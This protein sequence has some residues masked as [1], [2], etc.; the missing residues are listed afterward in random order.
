MGTQPVL[1]VVLQCPWKRGKLQKW[2]PAVW[3]KEFRASRTGTCLFREVL[4]LRLYR[5]RFANANPLLADMPSGVF[6]P[7]AAH[8]KRRIRAVHQNIILVCGAVAKESLR[9]LVPGVPI[10]LMPHPASRS[11]SKETTKKIKKRLVRRHSF[12]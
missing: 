9:K 6:P 11:L 2:H 12:S 7:D 1:L 10:V 4:P 5:I 3:R 8:I